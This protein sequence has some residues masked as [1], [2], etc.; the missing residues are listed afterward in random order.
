[1]TTVHDLYT[2]AALARINI[3]TACLYTQAQLELEKYEDSVTARQVSKWRH[4]K[5][6]PKPEKIGALE[7]ALIDLAHHAGTLPVTDK[8]K[9]RAMGI[10]KL[11]ARMER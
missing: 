10:R 8:D 6:E 11:V 4:S 9:A 7:T 5:A 2:F 3:Q 1:M